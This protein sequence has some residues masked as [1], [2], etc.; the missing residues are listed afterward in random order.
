[1]TGKAQVIPIPKNGDHS[2]PANYR[3]ISLTSIMCKMLEH[4]WSSSIYTH[5]DKYNIL[6]M[7]M[8]SV[9][10]DPVIHS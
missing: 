2:S 10:E 4:I 8:D 7:D 9:K 5:L 6:C 3:P 1:M